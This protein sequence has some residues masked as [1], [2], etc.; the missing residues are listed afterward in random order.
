MTFGCQMNVHDSLRMQKILKSEGYQIS[1]DLKMA[2]LVLLN[3]CSVRE[4]PENKIYSQIGRLA[5]QKKD[6]PR[7][8]IAVAGCVAQQEGKDILRRHKIVDMVFGTDQ[9]LAL[10]KMLATVRAGGR[11]L[12]TAWMP[13][14][15]KI[16]NFIPEGEL[17]SF[18][19]SGAAA[20]VSI[21][22]GCDNYC[23]FCIVPTTRG[24]LVSRELEN[25]INEVERLVEKGTK[26]VMLLGQNVNSYAAQNA[27]F[28]SLLQAV[29][30]IEGLRRIRF[31]SPHPNDWNNGLSD[32]MAAR[33]NICNQLHLPF[34]AGSDRILNA[35]KRDHTGMGYVEKIKYLKEKIPDIGLSTD[36]IVGFPSETDE[37]FEKTL[38]VMREAKFHQIYA[39]KYSPRPGTKADKL[40]D[41]VP[42][43]IK[44]ARLAQVFELHELLRNDILE[45]HLG[46]KGEIIIESAHP[47]KQ[48]IMTGRMDNNVPISI[49]NSNL[50]IGDFAYVEITGRSRHTLE[51]KVI[52]SLA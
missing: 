3:S 14:E 5:N 23:T 46:Q 50:E 10:P 30:N 42:K 24:P 37:D 48:G 18:E 36:I 45:E 32:L 2:D 31:M 27:N 38:M 16:Q 22:K 17:G 19:V 20:M 51:G 4:G 21:T 28:Y 25:I 41:D 44:D 34:Q 47:K 52:S 43:E 49:A 13:R 1:N 40:E 26:E 6:N 11:A 29:S 12:E 33:V 8:I 35:M 7:L 9:I 39:Y 15:N